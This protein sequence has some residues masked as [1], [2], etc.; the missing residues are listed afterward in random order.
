LDAPVRLPLAQGSAAA[1]LAPPAELPG[2]AAGFEAEGGRGRPGAAARD[3][4]EAGAEG[5]F[6]SSSNM[7]SIESESTGFLPEASP[8]REAGREAGREGAAVLEGRAA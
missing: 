4:S 7:S 3:R 6:S 8:P 1:A 5:V 2:R